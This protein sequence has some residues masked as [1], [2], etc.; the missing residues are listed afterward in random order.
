[1]AG[2]RVAKVTVEGVEVAV[3]LDYL[4]SW[5]GIRLAAHM[6]SKERSD[7]DRLADMIAYYEGAIAN[8]DEVSEGMGGASADAVLGL[9]SSAVR[10]ATPKN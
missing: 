5:E 3:D 1:M 4:R 7:A 6:Q 9:L 8:I 2:K 10:E